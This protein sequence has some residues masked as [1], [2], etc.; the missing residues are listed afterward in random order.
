MVAALAVGCGVEWTPTDVTARRDA[1]VGGG[2]EA[3]YPAVG[4][5][6]TGDSTDF[7]IGPY[8]GATLIAPNLAVTAGHCVDRAPAH[9]VALGPDALRFAAKEVVV[10]PYFD[11]RDRFQHDMALVVLAQPATGIEPAVVARATAGTAYRYVGYGRTTPGD[12]NVTDGYTDERK[13][14]AMRV[15]SA[16]TFNVFTQGVG[17]GLCWGD[18]GGPLMEEDGGAAI[19]GVLADFD[20]VFDCQ[21][22]NKMIFTSLHNERGFIAAAQACSARASVS[23][24]VAGAMRPGGLVD[25]GLGCARFCEEVPV[26]EGECAAGQTCD[27]LCAVPATCGEPLGNEAL[28]SAPTGC[29]ATGGLGLPALGLALVAL[30]RRRPR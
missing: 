16:D 7:L 26:Q 5:F 24:C 21:V 19:Y 10:H 30:R 25:G 2:P 22:G 11:T 3:R 9:G 1:V 8:C 13:S 4:Y 17:G 27:G 20:G 18:S 14:T 23:G 15:R 29:S 6:M 28:P 12:V